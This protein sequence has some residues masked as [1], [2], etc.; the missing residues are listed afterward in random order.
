MRLLEW[1][2]LYIMV[3]INPSFLARVDLLACFLV[4]V[5]D[6]RE[7]LVSDLDDRILALALQG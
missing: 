2:P 1:F 5:E 7:Q 4:D 6:L 3:V